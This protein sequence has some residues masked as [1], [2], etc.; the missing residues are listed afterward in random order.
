MVLKQE[1]ATAIREVFQWFNA[2]KLSTNLT[3]RHILCKN[4][5]NTPAN[6]NSIKIK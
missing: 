6:L 1:L 5:T 2:N 3:K 4:T